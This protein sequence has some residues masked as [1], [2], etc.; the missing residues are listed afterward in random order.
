MKLSN[1]YIVL[2]DEAQLLSNHMLNSDD[3]K[4]LKEIKNFCVK[5]V[6]N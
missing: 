3:Q 6:N 1:K 5:I 4:E 2:M